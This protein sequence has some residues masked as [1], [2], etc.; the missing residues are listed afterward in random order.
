MRKQVFNLDFPETQYGCFRVC[1]LLTFSLVHGRMSA[2]GR[3][4]ALQGR[5]FLGRKG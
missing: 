4:C 1:E 5:Q 3:R 2:S